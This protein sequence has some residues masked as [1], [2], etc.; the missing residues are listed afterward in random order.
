MST[1]EPPKPRRRLAAGDRRE[2]IERAAT[3]LFAERG[4]RGASMNDIARRSGISV[5]VLYDHFPSKLELHKRLLER[6]FADLR[7]V[8][9]SHLP[10][11][12]AAAGD[13]MAAVVDAWFGYVEAHPYA[14]R[15]LFRDTSAD[16]QVA[17]IHREVAERS[18][19][20]L[21]PLV[22]R[23]PAAGGASP[24]AVELLWEVL[25][26][27]LQGLALWWAD[28]P[29]VPRA[30]VVAAAM[31]GV[32]LGLERLDAGERWEPPAAGS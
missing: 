20:A 14:T 22:A 9:R 29:D 17:A 31:N 25:R 24:V 11:T 6:H 15:M 2:R 32:W 16:P 27:T 3:E 23:E 21:L 7:G 12:D 13:R 1:S 30:D 26:A 10:L 19:A 5:P 18:K 28:H 4:Y 8:W